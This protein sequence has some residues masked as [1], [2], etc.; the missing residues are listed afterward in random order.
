MPVA[1][2]VRALVGM[3][4]ERTVIRFLYGR[5]LETLLATWGISLILIQAVRT[6][7]GAQ[8]VQVENPSWMAGGIEVMTGVVL[9]WSRIVIIVFAAPVLAADLA[10]C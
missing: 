7:F 6:I 9:P 5:P 2:A 1:F 8:N 10:R 4:L 3:V